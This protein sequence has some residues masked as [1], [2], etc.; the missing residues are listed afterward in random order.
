MAGRLGNALLDRVP[1][2]FEPDAQ[3]NDAQIFIRISN[4]AAVAAD[5]MV[6]LFG[7]VGGAQD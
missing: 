2:T 5:I 1:H 4:Q 6:A 7:V 3:G